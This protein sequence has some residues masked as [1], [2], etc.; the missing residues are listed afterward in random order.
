MSVVEELLEK[1]SNLTLTEA[2]ELKKAL[3]E[4]K[5]H[6]LLVIG[7]FVV[8]FLNI[9][10]FQ[11]GNGRVGRLLLNFILLK[12][13]Y[14]PINI[15]LEDRAEYYKTLQEYSKKDNL[16]PTLEFLIKQYKKNLKK[17][18]TKRGK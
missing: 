14:P 15:L 2:S 11:D 13:N 4:K 12:N 10:P 18:P 7:N 1:I 3:E 16:K 8:E 5:I 9:H 6:P 17:V